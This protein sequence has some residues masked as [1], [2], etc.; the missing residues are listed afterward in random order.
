MQHE[1]TR[2]KSDR[3]DILNDDGAF[4]AFLA[5][6]ADGKILITFRGPRRAPAY[7]YVDPPMENARNWVEAIAEWHDTPAAIRCPF[8]LQIDRP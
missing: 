6:N 2:H 3:W 4:A 8:P 5:P 1:W 7:A